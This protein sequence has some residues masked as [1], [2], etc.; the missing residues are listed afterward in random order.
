MTTTKPVGIQVIGAGLPRTATSSLQAALHQLGYQPCQHMVSDVIRDIGG[1]GHQW[2]QA[3]QARDKVTRHAILREI[4]KDYRAIVDAPGCFFVEDLMEIYPEAKVVLGLRK[5]PEAWLKS[6]NETIG[7]VRY[8]YT[9]YSLGFLLPPVRWMWNFGLHWEKINRDR[10]HTPVSTLE[11]YHHH[12]DYIR[13]VVPKHR[14]LEF[15]PSQGWEPLCKFL[16]KPIPDSPYPRLNDA[17]EMQRVLFYSHFVGAGLWGL[18]GLALFGVW[19]G[20]H[21]VLP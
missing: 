17:K 16:E 12:N 2:T 1:L 7:T 20:I 19:K 21:L 15:E 3:L 18:T 10:Y 5:S 11:T 9:W 8:N 14:L 4:C 6:Y 13:R